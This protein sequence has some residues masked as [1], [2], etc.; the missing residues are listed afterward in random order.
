[1][2][3]VTDNAR[4][5]ANLLIIFHSWAW[6]LIHHDTS[7]CNW[8]EANRK[9]TL[10]TATNKCLFSASISPQKLCDI[11]KF[12]YWRENLKSVEFMWLK[13]VLFIVSW[14]V[15]M[16]RALR[17]PICTYL[18]TIYSSYRDFPPSL[19]LSPLSEPILGLS[20]TPLRFILLLDDSIMLAIVCEFP[21]R[22]SA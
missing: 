7:Q 11:S 1:M 18:S 19:G 20:V 15:W 13:V 10:P 9:I 16:L 21:P 3:R 12:L 22:M 17:T 6:R 4:I 8:H 2:L 14:F 5:V